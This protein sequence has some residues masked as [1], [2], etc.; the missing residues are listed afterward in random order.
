MGPDK[1]TF[2]SVGIGPHLGEIW[3]FEILQFWRFFGTLTAIFSKTGRQIFT[4]F[5][6]AGQKYNGLPYSTAR[7]RNK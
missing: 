6:H 5:L 3:A 1:N 4:K 7:F 2:C